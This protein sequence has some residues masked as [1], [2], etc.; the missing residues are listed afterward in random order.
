MKY[1]RIAE[2]KSQFE[3]FAKKVEENGWTSLGVLVLPVPYSTEMTWDAYKQ[4]YGIDLEKLFIVTK[5]GTEYIVKPN[6]SVTKLILLAPVKEYF[7]DNARVVPMPLFA[8]AYAT[9]P[10]ENIGKANINLGLTEENS[11]LTISL[12]IY[13]NKTI[14]GEFA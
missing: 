7:A 11:S 8:P 6:P 10:A 14:L 5:L 4:T 3:D 9:L 2:D 1:N 13:A 12:S